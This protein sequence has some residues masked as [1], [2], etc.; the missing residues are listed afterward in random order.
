MFL[1]QGVQE[2]VL[3]YISS[4]HSVYIRL[5]LFFP[6]LN[7]VEVLTYSQSL[8][9]FSFQFF[10]GNWDDFLF[11]YKCFYSLNVLSQLLLCQ[12][13]CPVI[14]FCFLSLFRLI[15]ELEVWN[16]ST[17]IVSE[18]GKKYLDN[19]RAEFI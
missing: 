4:T 19:C 3:C 8:L 7:F 11:A 13:L 18:L 17:E 14:P 1:S 6:K 15:V 2:C 12:E 9:F 5:S 16:L 10:G